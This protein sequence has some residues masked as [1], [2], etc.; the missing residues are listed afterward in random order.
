MVVEYVTTEK[1]IK[2][3]LCTSHVTITCVNTTYHKIN[4][5]NRKI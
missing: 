2:S 3:K 1:K 4:K 5:H